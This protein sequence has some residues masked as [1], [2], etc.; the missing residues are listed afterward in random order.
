MSGRE[1]R[2]AQRRGRAAEWCA[3]LWLRL[4]GYRILAR[5]WRVGAGEIDLVARR[6]RRLVFVEVKARADQASA[7]EAVSARQQARIRRAA[8][9]FVAGRPDLATLEQSFDAILVL[10][11]R[12]PRRVPDAWRDLPT[13]TK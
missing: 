13:H 6:G 8:E 4:G 2:R 5:N 11:W 1:R 9:A 3:A 10:P 12:L 7:L